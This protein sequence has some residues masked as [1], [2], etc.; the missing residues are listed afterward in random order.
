MQRLRLVALVVF[1]LIVGHLLFP[2]SLVLQ[3]WRLSHLTLSD[4][5]PMVYLAAAYT[6]LIY[7]SGAW[8]WFGRVPR[9]ALPLLLVVAI[10]ARWVG[11]DAAAS[12]SAPAT[13]CRPVRRSAGSGI[14]GTRWS[15]TFTFMPRRAR[16]PAGSPGSPRSR[17]RSAG[18]SW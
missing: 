14:R 8:S 10:A 18:D 16:T 2:A 17:S 12:R 15:H 9:R 6:G 7:L 13:A 11:A 3:V 1:P 5:L 4:W